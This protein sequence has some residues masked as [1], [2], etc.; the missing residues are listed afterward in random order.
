MSKKIY[1]HSV[2]KK[3]AFVGVL[4]REREKS[5]NN[6]WFVSFFLG[7]IILVILNFLEDININITIHLCGTGKFWWGMDVC[8]VV[9]VSRFIFMYLFGLS[10]Q[11]YRTEN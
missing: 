6:S 10:F 3:V 9:E 5:L 8:N 11:R 2:K 7:K 4:G 1:S